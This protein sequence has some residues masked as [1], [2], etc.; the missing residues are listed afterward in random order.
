MPEGSASRLAEALR[1]LR[2]RGFKPSGN[3][4]GVRSFDGALGCKGGAIRI[5]FAIADW[6][7]LTYPSITV[8][9][10]L[11]V[12]PPL[13]PHVYANGGLCYFAT[14]AVVLDRYDPAESIAQCLDQ[15]QRV[16]ERIRQDPGYRHDDVQDE[17]LQHWSHGESSAVYPVLIGTVDQSTKSSN[18][19]FITIGDIP[20]AVIADSQEEVSG[21]AIALGAKPP[22]QT[23]CPCW[24]F[25]TNV[26]PAV[27]SAMPANV[28]ELLAW[29]Q[30]WDRQLYQQV[31]LVLE[32]EPQY[33]KYTIATFAVSTPLGWLGFGFGLDPVHRLGAAKKPKLYRQFLH[34]RGGTRKIIRLA[35]TEFGPDFVHSRNLTFAD[36]KSKRVSVIGCGAIGSHV[37]PCL[38]RLGAGTGNGRL[39]LV[40][41]DTMNPENLGRH[42]LGYPALFKPKAEG[43][44]EE[45]RRQFPLSTVR[46]RVR[47]AR[48]L[49][50][51]FDADLV[52]DATGEEAVSELMNA[53]RIERQVDTP[54]LHVRIRGNGES[55]QTFWAQGRELGCFR[56]LLQAD[57]KNYR[58]ERYPILK[59]EPQRKQLGC[60]GF[61]PYAVSAPMAA[62]ALCMEVIVDW[63]QTGRP[64]PRFRTNATANADVY[65]VKNQDVKRLQAC[66]ACGSI[67]AH[68]V[69][70]RS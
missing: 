59:A 61:T 34:T 21:L 38:I 32:R 27:P 5:R 62:A 46:A 37:A 40:D 41:P 39:D 17:F 52:I 42:L 6:D 33:L 58:Q 70:V 48:D 12:L 25:R 63:L 50:D 60:N 19:W 11:D 57:H 20:H 47:N 9:D 16:L 13:S 49:A 69:A 67:D 35:I 23:R 22:T 24:L 44:A 7:F 45:M 28:K 15:A 8:L 43:L 53:M 3:R 54:V 4:G 56:C 31:Q 36:L 55:V 26:L 68:A 10:H 51:L 30:A 65:A 29:L 64:S 14:G 18:Y 66:P 2:S 1:L